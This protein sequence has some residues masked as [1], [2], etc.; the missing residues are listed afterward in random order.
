MTAMTSATTTTAL[1]PLQQLL[2]TET[3]GKLQELAMTLPAT[4]E[5]A[6]SAALA[7]LAIPAENATPEQVEGVR[8]LQ[9]RA[10]DTKNSVNEQRS[11]VTKQLDSFKKFWTDYENRLKAIEDN[12][13]GWLNDR[14]KFEAQQAAESQKLEAVK[15]QQA[16]AAAQF[17]AMFEGLVRQGVED[18]IMKGTVHIKALTGTALEEFSATMTDARWTNICV[19]AEKTSKEKLALL[20][21]NFDDQVAQ[22]KDTL[23]TQLWPDFNRRLMEVKRAMMDATTEEQKREV[24][25]S[26]DAEVAANVTSI[27]QDA[28]KEAKA[29]EIEAIITPS[30]D[31]QEPTIQTVRAIKNPVAVFATPVDWLVALGWAMDN[32]EESGVN[33]E[34][35]AKN[36]SK[37]QTWVNRKAKSGEVHKGL[38][39]EEEIKAK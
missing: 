38:K 26:V 19:A 37:V 28:A 21:H 2:S 30:G 22:I 33:M 25:L 20:A 35:L 27:Q 17:P 15:R 24:A 6:E 7:K 3:I 9:K 4:L 32:A 34:W 13:Q 14:A 36:L 12:S 8:L 11:P 23:K 1:Q 10:K 29:A 31:A 16:A 39:Y 5:K 18:N